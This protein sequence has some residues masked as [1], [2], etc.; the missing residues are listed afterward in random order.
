M[1]FNSVVKLIISLITCGECKVDTIFF[2]NSHLADW[3]K[4]WCIFFLMNKYICY[5]MNK[6]IVL[7]SMN[8]ICLLNNT[9]SVFTFSFFLSAVDVFIYKFSWCAAHTWLFQVLF[10]MM[11]TLYFAGLFW[12]RVVL[13]G[14]YIQL[15]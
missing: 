15:S 14:I 12:K 2:Q 7:E 4:I 13:Q 11:L 5:N 6:F 9:I 8:V 10:C 1:I 3:Y